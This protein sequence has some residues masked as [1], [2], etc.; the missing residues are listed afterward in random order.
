MRRL[1]WLLVVL[2]ASLPSAGARADDPADSGAPTVSNAPSDAGARSWASCVENV[3]RGAR[4]P[5]LSE[6]FPTRG[7]SG[8]AARLEITVTHGKGETVLPQGFRVAGESDAA[9]ALKEAGFV[10]PDPDGGVGPTITVVPSDAGAVTKLVIPFVALPKDPGRNALLLP[11]IPITISRANNDVVT[12]C[13]RVH[14]ILI[15]DPIA[16]ELDPQVKPSPPARPQREDWEL[17]RRLTLGVGIGVVVGAIVAFLLLRWM[18]R[19]R[20]VPP[21]PPRLPWVVALEELD[22]LRR[23]SLLTEKR[24]AEYFARVSDCVRKYLGARYGFDGLESTTDEIRAVLKRVRPPVPELKKIIAFLADCDLVKFARVIPDE[25][26]CVDARRKGET[27]VRTTIPL[28]VRADDEEPGPSSK[29]K[30]T[31]S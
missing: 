20:F 14:P 26:D 5:L 30:E 4:R 3:P 8:Y 7:F 24:T 31:A 25:D 1:A 29:R 28:N 10:F 23:S 21:P 27:I 11:P 15:E 2:L 17:L 9:R 18:R 12:V 22:D 16:N 19:P 13:T 6:V